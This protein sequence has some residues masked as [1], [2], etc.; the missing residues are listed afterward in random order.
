MIL[1]SSKTNDM[2]IIFE[3]L[4]DEK[5]HQHLRTCA[6]E[7][8]LDDRIDDAKHESATEKVLV[9]VDEWRIE[10][11]GVGVGEA[12]AGRQRE[13]DCTRARLVLNV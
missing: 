7:F 4:L 3:R 8:L 13:I 5:N 10:G 6:R 1:D 12:L 9:L 11:G 2:E